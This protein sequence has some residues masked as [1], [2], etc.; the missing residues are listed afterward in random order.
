MACSSDSVICSRVDFIC[1]GNEQN[2][3]EVSSCAEL[4]QWNSEMSSPTQPA[5]RADALDRARRFS[6]FLRDA[7]QAHPEIGEAFLARGAT[8]AAELALS[9]DGDGLEA[10]LR[11]QRHGLA[12]AVALGDLAGEMS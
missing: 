5:A 1:I 11:R 7:L 2:A 12:L 10:Q 6:P 3:A 9:A 4:R 8:V